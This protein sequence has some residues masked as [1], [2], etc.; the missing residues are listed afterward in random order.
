[1]TL[2]KFMSYF[3][4]GTKFKVEVKEQVSSTASSYEV[5]GSYTYGTL[6]NKYDDAKV[7]TCT[8]VD[9]DPGLIITIEGGD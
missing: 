9:Q 2:K 6:P 5:I 3:S 7:L 4:Y 8:R 1:M